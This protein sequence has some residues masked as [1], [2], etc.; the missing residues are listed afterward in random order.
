MKSLITG[1]KKQKLSKL[2][3]IDTQ[4]PLSDCEETEW[5][6]KSKR[7][8][9]MDWEGTLS[10]PLQSDTVMEFISD[11][12]S[13][14][15]SL[16]P[17][18]DHAIDLIGTDVEIMTKLQMLRNHTWKGKIMLSI[19][20]SVLASIEGKYFFTTKIEKETLY[21]ELD[22]DGIKWKNLQAFKR[23][24]TNSTRWYKLTEVFGTDICFMIDSNSD[25]THFAKMGLLKTGDF[26]Q[27][28]ISWKQKGIKRNCE[29]DF[30]KLRIA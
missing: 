24:V 17:S 12:R 18:S 13:A 29:I 11:C 23:Y 20:D 10:Q 30:N 19:F 14:L 26:D 8:Q 16:F 21:S 28:I 27:W 15:Q 22:P 5:R 4:Q 7:A 3:E 9:D 6:R 1:K 25:S 2:V